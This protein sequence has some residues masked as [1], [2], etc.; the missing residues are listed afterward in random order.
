MNSG[1]VSRAYSLKIEDSTQEENWRAFH[2]KGCLEIITDG[3]LKEDN[4]TF[5]WSS[6]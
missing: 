2:P 5:G 4:A 3:G 1:S 6:Y